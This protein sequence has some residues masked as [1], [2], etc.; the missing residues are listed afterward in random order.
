MLPAAMQRACLVETPTAAEIAWV[1]LKITLQYTVIVPC[2]MSL[3]S[4]SWRGS[5]NAASS[6]C[7][8]HHYKMA[9]YGPPMGCGQICPRVS[10]WHSITLEM[11]HDCPR[12]IHAY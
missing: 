9:L 8:S 12:V 11:L 6:L 2:H 10:A 5:A 4:S 7:L 1:Q 3:A